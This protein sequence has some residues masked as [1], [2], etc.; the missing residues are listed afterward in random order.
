MRP[1]KTSSC[2]RLESWDGKP[3]QSPVWGNSEQRSYIRSFKF[4]GPGGVEYRWALG[5][6]GM[7]IPRVSP[8]I[9]P[10][11]PSALNHVFQP[12]TL[13]ENKTVIAQFHRALHFPKKQRARLEVQPEGM[14]MLDYIILTFVFVEDEHR[15]REKRA[16]SGNGH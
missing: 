8:L 13:D 3:L 2:P 11:I 6:T 7:K 9:A 12:V 10:K 4:T 1:L 15:E 5:V 16:W 14:N